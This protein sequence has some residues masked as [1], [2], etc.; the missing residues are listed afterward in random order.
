MTTDIIELSKQEAVLKA[1]IENKSLR[2][3]S[4]D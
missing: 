1:V 2:A 3:D 4:G